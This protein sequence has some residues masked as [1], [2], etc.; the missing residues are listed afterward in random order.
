MLGSCDAYDWRHFYD[1]L[2]KCYGKT[3]LVS[4]VDPVIHVSSVREIPCKKRRNLKDYFREKPLSL[5]FENKNNATQW[6]SRWAGN[7]FAPGSWRKEELEASWGRTGRPPPCRRSS[8]KRCRPRRS[9]RQSSQDFSPSEVGIWKC[10]WEKGV[11]TS[12]SLL[13]LKKRTAMWSNL[14]TSPPRTT[15]VTFGRMRIKQN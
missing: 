4:P 2:K 1:Q 12:L 5:F 7:C 13:V 3:K 15:S 6:L 14:L 9:R 11:P 10:A 8:P